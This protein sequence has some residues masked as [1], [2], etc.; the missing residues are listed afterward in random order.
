M[1]VSCLIKLQAKSENVGLFKGIWTAEV[2]TLLGMR[3]FQGL[4]ASRI[5]KYIDGMSKCI[6][7]TLTAQL[8][9][10][11]APFFMPAET[12]GTFTLVAV[13]I[14]YLGSFTYVA[15]GKIST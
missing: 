14:T 5:L 9:V 7:N 8:S 13:V 2:L 3:A 11:F 10:G 15:S 12:V 1:M 4:A 6:A